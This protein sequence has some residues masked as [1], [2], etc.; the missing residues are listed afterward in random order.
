MGSGFATSEF[1]E[2]RFDQK[3]C[4]EVSNGTKNLKLLD[5]GVS[6]E[7]RYTSC[8]VGIVDSCTESRVDRGDHGAM[9]SSVTSFCRFLLQ[10]FFLRKLVDARL[11]G[12]KMFCKKVILA[13]KL[14]LQNNKIASNL[15][16]HKSNNVV[17]L[18]FEQSCSI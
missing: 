8:N 13:P 15:A 7:S 12:K 10:F 14:L 1:F 4:N 16:T 3:H 11:L 18:H 9:C 2:K 6:S 17:D 5:V